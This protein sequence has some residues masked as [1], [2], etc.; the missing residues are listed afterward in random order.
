MRTLPSVMFGVEWRLLRR[1]IP[2]SRRKRRA[3]SSVSSHNAENTAKTPHPS[4]WKARLDGR[5]KMLCL[6]VFAGVGR[7]ESLGPHLA[8]LL[9]LPRSREQ[10]L[11]ANV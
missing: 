10:G 3:K 4:L 7:H 5:E 8:R 2:T 9:R 1:N 11:N 6:I